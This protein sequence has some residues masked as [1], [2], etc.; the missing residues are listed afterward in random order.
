MQ[1]SDIRTVAII[2]AGLMGHGIAQDFATHGYDVRLYAR[3]QHRL[4]Q[5]LRNIQSGLE[6]LQQLGQLTPEQVAETPGRIRTGTTLEALVGD[7]D[8]VIEAV[9]EDLGVK[10]QVFRSLDDACPQRT[11]IASTTSALLPSALAT[12]THRP[13]RVIVAHYFNPPTLVPLVELVRGPETSDESVTTLR[14]LLLQ[15]GKRPALVQIEV[16]GFIG[17]RLQAALVREAL[18]LVEHGVATPADIDSVVKYSFGRRLAVAGVFEIG[19]LAG[20]DLYL[21]VGTLL[22]PSLESSPDLP[23]VLRNKVE[24]GA[25]G[26]KTGRGFYSWTPESAAALRS[27]IGQALIELARFD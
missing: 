14:D 8:L 2:G 12:A 4:D 9:S 26:A 7:A 3:S 23:S 25:L 17:N 19:D 1:A 20:L 22:F 21:S 13:D 16:P 18:S 11:I 15:M 10:Q 27:R 5:A 24:Q 6:L